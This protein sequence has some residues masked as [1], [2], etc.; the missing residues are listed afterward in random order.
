V[1]VNASPAQCHR[2]TLGC[3][4]AELV[5]SSN[6][7]YTYKDDTAGPGFRGRTRVHFHPIAA[8]WSL[9]WQ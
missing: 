8:G 5:N 3:A 1:H 9:Q 6:E 4:E 7:G 2:V